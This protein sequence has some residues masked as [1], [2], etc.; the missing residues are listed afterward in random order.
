MHKKVRE[1]EDK[2]R[3]R[4][5]VD[6]FSALN[7]D[8][9]LMKTGDAIINNHVMDENV[10]D[11]EDFQNNSGSIKECRPIVRYYK[12]NNEQQAVKI[13]GE[14][15]TLPQKTGHSEILVKQSSSLQENNENI[16]RN[17]D[18][19]GWLKS[20]KRK[21]RENLDRRKRQRY[22]VFDYLAKAH[23]GVMLLFMQNEIRCDPRF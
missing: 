6:I 8:D 4:K 21:W 13:T 5:L 10:E 7:K 3:Q 18:Y 15:D 9:L 22:I 12:V 14:I 20:K 1:K 16:D 17:I 23:F 2:F 11:L 19:Q